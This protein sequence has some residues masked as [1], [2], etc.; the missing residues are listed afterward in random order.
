MKFEVDFSPSSVS[1]ET[2]GS[3]KTRDASSKSGGLKS[4]KAL[5]SRPVVLSLLA[6]LVVA[7]GTA[8]VFR[9]SFFHGAEI[10]ASEP[11][12]VVTV[13]T[14]TVGLSPVNHSLEVTGSVSAWDPLSIGSEANGL[15]IETI[16]VEEGDRVSKGQVL[17][18]LNSA[19]LR[20]QLEQA[21]ARLLSSQNHL[22]KA[23][24]PNRFEDIQSLKAALSQS[25]ANIAQQEAMLA[26][27]EANLANAERNEGR[28]AGLVSQGAV[29]QADYDARQTTA[30]TAQAE[31]N[32]MKE[33][34]RSAHFGWRQAQEKLSMAEIGG[35]TE[36][37]D[38]SK[39]SVAENLATVRQL[40]AQVDQ[41]I[42]RAPADALVIKRDGH[43][44]DITSAGKPLFTLMRNNRL[45]LRAQVPEADLVHLS[46]GQKVKL[47]S[48]ADS[49]LEIIGVIR[50][51]SPIVDAESRL[52]TVRIDVPSDSK[53]RPGMF[54]RGMV[55]LGKRPA[56]TVPSTAV[57]NRDGQVF[58]FTLSGKQARR[59]TVQTGTY[60]SDAVE[61][62][63]GL[64]ADDVV[65][66]NGGGFL[67][68]GDYVRVSQ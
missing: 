61:I 7:A 31:V 67:K 57:F 46:A 15:K 50:E 27:A 40:Q 35:R 20:A 53:I 38:I 39:A 26:Q 54:L 3:N 16:N 33:S 4:V 19:V 56:I 52:G 17:A 1:A 23:I 5:A 45:E 58:V 22:K 47:A 32:H 42:I 18:T 65:I 60:T 6:I 41:T 30:K 28:F 9:N 12:P 8:V 55:D 51:I 64:K 21:Q 24:Q 2:A 34:I 36:D 11:P 59:R 25:K 68:D 37:I 66:S 14:S 44:G 63:S 29:S 49:A 43:I 48:Y 10:A 13:S 62:V